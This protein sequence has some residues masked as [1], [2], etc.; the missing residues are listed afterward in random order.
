MFVVLGSSVSSLAS[1]M[2]HGRRGLSLGDS[3]R[4]PS[5][6]GE[7]L[8]VVLKEKSELHDAEAV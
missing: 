6:F 3:R 1:L 2:T 5:L 8:P 4:E 7:R